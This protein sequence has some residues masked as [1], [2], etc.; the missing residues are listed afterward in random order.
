MNLHPTCRMIFGIALTMSIISLLFWTLVGGPLATYGVPI[1]IVCIIGSFFLAGI[2][3][4]YISKDIFVDG[5]DMSDIGPDTKYVEDIKALKSMYRTST[6]MPLTS[7]RCSYLLGVWY[8]RN[9]F[10][11]SGVK[12]LPEVIVCEIKYRFTRAVY[13]AKTMWAMATAYRTQPKQPEQPEQT[14]TTKDS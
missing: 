10:K 3:D 1:S 8:R 5:Y 4:T 11:K 2:V 14:E 7:S 6:G 9:N 12:S 13:I